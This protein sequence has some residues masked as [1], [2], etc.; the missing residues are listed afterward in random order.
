VDD[1]ERE[2]KQDLLT[3][4]EALVD[5]Q[6]R[7]AEVLSVVESSTDSEE[8]VSR[9]AALLGLTDAHSAQAVLD[10]P[11]G[12][13]TQRNRERLIEERDSLRAALREL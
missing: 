7:R 3:I 11:I 10:M 6:L 13:W 12:R 9:L 4:V 2:R 5:A 1:R 8:A